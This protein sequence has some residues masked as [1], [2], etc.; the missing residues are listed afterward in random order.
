[1]LD[2]G[3][4]LDAGNSQSSGSFRNLSSPDLVRRIIADKVIEGVNYALLAS[5][6][7]TLTRSLA[8]QGVIAYLEDFAPA[9][10]SLANLLN[11]TN[12]RE[13]PPCLHKAIGIALHFNKSGSASAKEVLW[14]DRIGGDDFIVL[15]KAHPATAA[16]LGVESPGSL[17]GIPLF[18][19]LWSAATASRLGSP[20]PDGFENGISKRIFK[21]IQSKLQMAPRPVKPRIRKPTSEQPHQ[22]KPQSAGSSESLILPPVPSIPRRSLDQRQPPSKT[23]ATTKPR[24]TGKKSSLPTPPPTPAKPPEPKPLIE[25]LKTPPALA[26]EPKEIEMKTE[27]PAPKILNN[28]VTDL[29][30]PAPAP[31]TTTTAGTNGD[32]KQLEAEPPPKL[33]SIYSRDELIDLLMNARLADWVE[34]TLTDGRVLS[35]SILFNEFTKQVRILNVDEEYNYNF[36]IE[37]IYDLRF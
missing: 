22:D 31:A 5:P 20:P 2:T 13:I 28:G 23:K 1:M 30:K 19:D 21:A 27:A 37:E 12:V 11:H 9:G 34:V 36:G 8:A 4:A 33:V 14:A 29:P 26:V 7:N 3:A 17:E 15:S 35:G 32:S 16:V 6:H 25:S 24:T 18:K 10:Y